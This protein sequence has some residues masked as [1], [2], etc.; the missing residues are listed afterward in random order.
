MHPVTFLAHLADAPHA[1]T[2]GLHLII[3]AMAILAI[4]LSWKKTG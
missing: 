2:E 3:L 1:H 4:F